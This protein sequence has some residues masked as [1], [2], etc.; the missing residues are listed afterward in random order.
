[1]RS[2]K[3]ASIGWLIERQRILSVDKYVR[4][5]P[6]TDRAGYPFGEESQ[7]AMSKLFIKRRSGQEEELEGRIGLSLMEI[8]RHNGVEELLAI[9][10]GC[11]SCATCHV[12][13]DL[14]FVDALPKIEPSEDDLLDSSD[15]RRPNS[16]LAC[17]IPYSNALDGLRLTMAPED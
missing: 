17:Q 9:C 3:A 7:Y 1:M 2:G 8:M 5:S 14:E 10:G 12:L 11:C 13:V 16:R 4:G 6:L 15:H